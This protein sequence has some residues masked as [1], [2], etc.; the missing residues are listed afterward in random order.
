VIIEQYLQ[1]LESIRVQFEFARS[2]IKG[3]I[4]HVEMQEKIEQALQASET[5]DEVIERLIEPSGTELSDEEFMKMIDQYMESQKG[6]FPEKHKDL[7]NRLAQNEIIIMVAV[8]EDVLKS[9][10]R[11]M[12]R[13]QPT[14][15]SSDRQISLGRLAAFGGEKIIEEEIE[16]AVQA[17]DR[18][19]VAEKAKVF[20]KIG[21]PWNKKP[22]EV[23]DI[24]RLRN[25]ILHENVERQVSGWELH[26][27]RKL[28]LRLPLHLFYLGWQL[29]PKTFAMSLPLA[30]YC[31]RAAENDLD[32]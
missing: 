29:Y 5:A 30:D 2:A 9:I 11:E 26:T 7:E 4:D 14:L 21:L 3:Y 27:C 18:Q 15:L 10:H 20:Q 16:R 1:R 22:E 17:L 25:E 13:Q 28:V 6:N 32:F 8:F 12:L 19:T 23:E 31:K 24:T